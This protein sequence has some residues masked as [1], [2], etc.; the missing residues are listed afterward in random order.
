MRS[1]LH[2]GTK[3]VFSSKPNGILNI[4]DILDLCNVN[5]YEPLITGYVLI[6]IDIAV[7]IT[8]LPS[9]CQINVSSEW[10]QGWLPLAYRH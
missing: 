8:V 2:S 10:H 7:A 6:V 3:L 4:C 1:A 5:R 9:Y